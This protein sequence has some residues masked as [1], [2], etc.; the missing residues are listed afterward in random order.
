MGRHGE[1]IPN[2]RA[3]RI[4]GYL[5]ML[6]RH[7][8]EV[9][10]VVPCK[11]DI[12]LMAGEQDWIIGY[13]I[14]PLVYFHPFLRVI[15]Q[16][17]QISLI[18][19]GKVSRQWREID[20]MNESEVIKAHL[21]CDVSNERFQLTSRVHLPRCINE[22]LHLGKIGHDPASLYVTKMRDGNTKIGRE[23]V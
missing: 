9:T 2:S 13:D 11:S 8:Y 21:S 19:M 23:Q 7:I 6:S 18:H 1:P 22:R 4:A 20:M 3:A 5:P 15:R 12:G 14:A 16:A 17:D 10:D